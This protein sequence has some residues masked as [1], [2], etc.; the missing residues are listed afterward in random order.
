MKYGSSA[1]LTFLAGCATTTDGMRS[2]LP[3]GA[4]Y[5]A[6]GS[7]FAAGAGIEPRK[8]GPDRCGRSARNYASLLAARL[9]LQLDDQSC[10]G[11]RA[12]DLLAPSNELPAQLDAVRP[13]TRLVTATI[14][15]NDLNYAG[16]L[17]ASG[18]SPDGMAI[19]G[20]KNFPCPSVNVPSEEDYE[21]LEA[22]MRAIVR[23]V[24]ARA[25]N[26]R[27]I[28]VQYVAMVP[29]QPCDAARLPREKAAVAR[30]IGRRLAEI[31]ARAARIERGEVLAAEQLSHDHRPCD[32]E[33]WSVGT[34]PL[35]SDGFIWHPNARGHAAIAEALADRLRR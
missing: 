3:S 21:R 13:D 20:G 35:P 26:A 30:A 17:F 5:V 19:I 16:Y 8:A 10:N 29:D 11:A 34:K 32:A 6:T 28:F 25:P 27:V 22:N 9:N 15:G 14:G 4:H 24:K 23:R 12:S 2:A 1:F 7:S 31:T 18:C 33:P